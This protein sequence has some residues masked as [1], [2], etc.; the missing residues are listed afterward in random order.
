MQ[1]RC[2]SIAEYYKLSG[3]NHRSSHA[4]FVVQM[5]ACASPGAADLADNGMRSDSFTFRD[6][7]AVKMGIARHNAGSV[8]DFNDTAIAVHTTGENYFPGSCAVDV[9]S[10]R[11]RHI[12]SWM[13]SRIVI[14]RVNTRAESTAE[15]VG[16][17]RYPE[18]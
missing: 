9:A 3:I 18:W 16:C 5:R 15:F 17:E 11:R 7:N 4:N 13:E 6:K 1:D 2:G 10:V 8:I 14:D 12:Y